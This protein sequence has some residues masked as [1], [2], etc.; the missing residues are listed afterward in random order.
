MT[1]PRMNPETLRTLLR[2]GLADLV[3]AEELVAGVV[4]RREYGDN[5]VLGDTGQL[6][7]DPTLTA[8]NLARRAIDRAAHE[9]IRTLDMQV[10]YLRTVEDL[11]EEY[12]VIHSDDET[13]E[14]V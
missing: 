8:L 6:S 14:A 1:A 11:T 2:L 13:P 4:R 5:I 7:D 3:R 9:L 12:V 10:P